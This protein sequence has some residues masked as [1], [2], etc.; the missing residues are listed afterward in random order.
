V[1]VARRLLPPLLFLASIMPAHAGLREIAVKS[2]KPWP[3]DPAR[4]EL[5]EAISDDLGHTTRQ[6]RIINDLALAPPMTRP[7]L[8]RRPCQRCQRL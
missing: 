5:L 2:R 8:Y 6:N 3:A 4:F 1:K 7:R